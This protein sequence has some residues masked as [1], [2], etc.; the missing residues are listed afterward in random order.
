MNQILDLLN[1]LSGTLIAVLVVVGVYLITQRII[2]GRIK[3]GS[4]FMPL[5]Q[6]ILAI[7]LFIGLIL[8][9]SSLPISDELKGQLLGLIGIVLSAALALSS[10]TLLGNALAALML[11]IVNP[12]QAGDFIRGKDFFGRVTNQGLF[13]TEIQTEDRDLMTIPNLVIASH[14]VKVI[15][16]SGTVIAA[17]CSL[18][19]DIKRDRIETA[20]VS[21]AESVG[22]KDPFVFVTE[23]GDF[24]ITYKLHGLLEHVD[25]LL[26]THSRLN[27]AMIDHLHAS[28]IEIVSPT[29]MNQ[30]Q[31]GE[32]VFIPKGRVIDSE[33][34]Q[35]IEK[36][37]FDKAEVA[38]KLESDQLMLE[39]IEQR[40]KDLER[41][42]KESEQS[43]ELE[44]KLESYRKLK[45]RLLSRMEQDKERLKEE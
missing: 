30:R 29:F 26:S 20:L 4:R 37:I 3:S 36:I 16:S 44:R 11:R 38:K 34:E 8:I 22:L 2:L 27:K 18:G 42:I 19:Y 45:N 5:R 39:D 43:E 15:R 28:G 13:H 21:A 7:I 1:S 23:L 25:S 17:S 32:Q 35:E 10:T 9:I 14:P 24:S 6:V 12:F 33:E 41:S 31:V 40:M